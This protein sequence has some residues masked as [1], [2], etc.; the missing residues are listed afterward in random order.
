M[1]K[2]LEKIFPLLFLI[3]LVIGTIGYLQS[4]EM[5]TNALYASFALYFTNPVSDAYN[6]LVEFARWT[7]PLMTATVILCALKNVWHKLIWRIQCLEK[8]SVAIY[9][10]QNI[11]I[12]FGENVTTIY[13]GNTFQPWAKSHIL[14]FS[15][16]QDNLK[17]YE[18][19][20]KKLKTDEV[21]I[22]LRELETGLL[23]KIDKI[24]F[25][26]VNGAIARNLW[27]QISV[28]KNREQKMDIVIYGNGALAEAI[29]TYG[30]Q[31]NLFSASQQITY[32]VISETNYFEIKH[33]N[34]QTQNE[35]RIISYRESDEGIWEIIR[36]AEIVIAADLLSMQKFQEIVVNTVKGQLYYYSPETGTLGDYITYGNPKAFGR[37][38]FIF[39]DEN[40]RRKQLVKKADELN[41]QYARNY[42]G[43]KE[44]RK[45]S[46]FLR[47]SNISSADFMEILRELPDTVQMEEAAE[48]EHICWCRFHY[49]NYWKYGISDNGARKDAQKR[50]HKDLIPYKEL[51]EA[52]KEKDRDIVKKA[53]RMEKV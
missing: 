39:T 6:G 13:A 34:F 32:H 41:K 15:S 11:S 3:P 29:L 43:E 53:R 20:K 35:D 25:F 24:D 28:W 21:Y 46:G 22:A 7:A 18:D 10:D 38:D 37:N 14:M 33:P 19:H 27:K 45:L 4:G 2:L 50:I 48:L 49:L 40:I 8:D 12:S 51:S 36:N 44:W 30:I 17:F 23:Q 5:I 42:G 47:A 26:D 1:K 31:M 52:E 16:D 9:S